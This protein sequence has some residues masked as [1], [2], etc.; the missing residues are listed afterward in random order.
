VSFSN[1]AVTS[2]EWG[3][4]P[5]LAFPELPEIEVL[6]MPRQ[7]EPPLGAGESASVPSA[8]A[9]ANAVF[10][11]TGVR[12]RELPLTPER[13][14]AALN[15][16][17]SPP[18][19]PPARGKRRW[20]R[21]GFPLAGTVAGAFALL[22]ATPWRAAI[23]PIARPAPDV[24]SA[25]TIERG[26]LAA[27]IGA[28]NVC[29]IGSDGTPFAG[30]RALETPFGVVYATNIT[31]DP[32]AGIGAWS[33]T[34]FARAMTEGVSR[35]GHHLYPAHPYPSFAKAEEADIEAL[36]A[37]LMSQTAVRATAP[38]T[39]LP[40][41][42]NSRPLMAAWN[43]LY[44]RPARAV[45]GDGGNRGA[46]LVESLGHCG[47]CHSPR[48]RLGAEMTGKWRLAGGVADGWDAPGLAAASLAPVGWNADALFTYLR[49]G[50]ARHHGSAAGPMAEVVAALRPLSDAD[51]RAM[52][53]YL[54]SL[55]PRAP[56]DADADLA[57]ERA[58]AADASAEAF[59]RIA[60]PRGARLFAGACE[61]CHEGSSDLIS[62]ALNSNSH[63]PRPDNVIQAVL[64]GVAPASGSSLANMPSFANA[65]DDDQL[66][67]L[68]RYIRRRFA[69]E[70][71]PWDEAP[72]TI[73]RLRERLENSLT[74]R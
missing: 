61:S 65:L 2:L 41:P 54:A 24:F 40:F 18:P 30:G 8:A 21:L 29:H 68:V 69:P 12:F 11:A 23:E 9:I 46:Y 67:D 74:R 31:P 42:F 28:C 44:L 57:A 63:G 14:R 64:H 25:A 73:R 71:P 34:A 33:Y 38:E 58:L 15:P 43:A 7:G 56:S 3:A 32:D 55:D 17:P 52:A 49:G 5:I 6:M 47:A 37:Y 59:A 50:R 48:N 10:D 35:D 1:N 22:T 20:P 19:E 36:Y 26:R 39:K 45:G 53:A 16:L 72:A 51:I 70:Q 27:A 13:V 62:F 4:Y 60:E 66:V